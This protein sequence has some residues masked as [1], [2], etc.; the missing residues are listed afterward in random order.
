MK[1]GTLVH[2]RGS[3]RLMLGTGYSLYLLNSP[4]EAYVLNDACTE[5]SVL[6]GTVLDWLK[7]HKANWIFA[8]E[9]T[10]MDGIN[11]TDLLRSRSIA[12]RASFALF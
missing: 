3:P 1:R 10:S 4:A 9:I 8:G 2:V 5:P 7:E 12:P 11:T 6:P